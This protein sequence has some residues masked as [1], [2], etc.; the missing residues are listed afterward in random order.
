MQTG[1]APAKGAG[2]FNRTAWINAQQSR[3]SLRYDSFAVMGS[4][5]TFAAVAPQ[6]MLPRSPERPHFS[7]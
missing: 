4:I 6:K 5:R 3:F 7:S 2:L 1:P